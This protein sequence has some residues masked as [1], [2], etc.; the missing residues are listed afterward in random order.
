[1]GDIVM[2]IIKT[3]SVV[4]NGVVLTKCIPRKRSLPVVIAGWTLIGLLC[5]LIERISGVLTELT[6]IGASLFIPFVF[7]AYSGKL[8]QMMY[9]MVLPMFFTLSQQMFVES[10]LRFFLPYGTDTYW[11][12]YLIAVLVIYAVYIFAVIKFGKRFFDK[13]FIQG[14]SSEWALYTFSS[15]LAFFAMGILYMNFIGVNTPVFFLA[16]CATSWS[17]IML[18]F[19]IINTHEKT[20]QK[21]E[22][23]LAREIISSGR[24]YYDKLTD[25]TEQIHI[26]RH[27]YKHHLAS[28]QK[29]IK[30]GADTEIHDY[31]EALD[32]DIDKKEINDYSASRVVNAL[33]D[34]FS[35]TC[36]KANIDF[37]VRIISPPPGTVDDYELCIILGN[38]F[39]NAITACLRTPENE[40]RY[41]E[42]SMRPRDNQYGIKVENSYDGVIKN[43]GKTLFTIKKDGGLG[44]KSIVSVARKY[45]GEYVPVWDEKKFSAFVVLKLK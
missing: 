16:L 36:K 34:S 14:R 18:C 19:A 17:Y 43:E 9:A 24:G 23:E 27:D 7:W 11:L 30:D 13:L 33:L 2:T 12:T 26:L 1:M 28:M 3:L 6:V 29:M 22:T 35:E 39:E 15:L 40:R 32:D 8:F 38:L 4:L 31:L 45:N 37:S 5:F 10:V 44:I 42:I 41:I 21:Y 25:M 20:R